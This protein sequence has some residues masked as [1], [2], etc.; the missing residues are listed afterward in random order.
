[1]S[2]LHGI[3][4]PCRLGYFVAERWGHAV[5]LRL[6]A[7]VVLFAPSTLGTVCPS[8]SR[9]G[10]HSFCGKGGARGRLAAD[11]LGLEGFPERA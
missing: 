4:N 3:D 10:V 8:L 2:L 5:Q 9:L 11:G 6:R 7:I 1:M